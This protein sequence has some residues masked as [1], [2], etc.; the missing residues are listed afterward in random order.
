SARQAEVVR[1]ITDAVHRNASDIHITVMEDR[2]VISFRIHGD[3][4][5]VQEPPAQKAQELCSTIYQSMCDQAEEI[6]KP[7]THQ[8]ARIAERFV[9][10]ARLFGARVASGPTDSGSDMVIRLLYDSGSRIPTL[11]ALG[12]L[13][14]HVALIDAMRRQTSGLNVLSGATGSGKSTTLASVLAQIL[15]DARRQGRSLY[16]DLGAEEFLGVKIIT[17]EDPPEYK[18][19]GAVQTPLRADK[20]EESAIRQGWADAIRACMRKDPDLLMIGEIR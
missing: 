12:Y 18:I 16:R 19:V 2:G 10:R 5:K 4:I 11:K 1:L 13:P 15:D 20:S 3:L 7:A 6:Y 8:D 14:E 9:S 17:V